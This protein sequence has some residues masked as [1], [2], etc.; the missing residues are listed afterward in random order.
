MLSFFGGQMCVYTCVCVYIGTK[1][2]RT[3]LIHNLP[4]CY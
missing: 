2:E 3:D 4:L 1:A